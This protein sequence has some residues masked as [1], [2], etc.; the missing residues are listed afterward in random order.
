M[1]KKTKFYTEE[2][3]FK[4]FDDY[5][6][7][8]ETKNIWAPICETCSK[9]YGASEEIPIRGNACGVKGCNNTAEYYIDF[10]LNA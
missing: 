4:I 2:Y 10:P 1:K 8:R 6:V 5:V 3:V 7:E 9:E